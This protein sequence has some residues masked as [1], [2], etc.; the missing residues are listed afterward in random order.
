MHLLVVQKFSLLNQ[1]NPNIHAIQIHAQQI[2][3]VKIWMQVDT[4]VHVFRLI[5]EILTR[6]VVSQSA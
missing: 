5:E 4:H 2:P 6:A 1:S 3:N